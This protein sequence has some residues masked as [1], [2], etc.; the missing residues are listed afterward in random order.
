MVNKA[1]KL[2]SKFS[3]GGVFFGSFLKMEIAN[4]LRKASVITPK[5]PTC[6]FQLWGAKVVGVFLGKEDQ[7]RCTKSLF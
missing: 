7:K 3:R 5:V 2:I 4:M 6:K 1:Q